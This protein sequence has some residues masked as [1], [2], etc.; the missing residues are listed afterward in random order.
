MDEEKQVKRQL[1]KNMLWN[2]IAF[3][4]I[5]YLFG[6]FVYS[7]FYGSL[8]L[9]ADS[10]LQTVI[11]QFSTDKKDRADIPKK[12]EREKVELPVNM[13]NPK[14]TDNDDIKEKHEMQNPRLI[15]I[16]R[17]ESGNIIEDS[18]ENSRVND[19]IKN[20]EFNKDNTY[21]IYEVLI[22]NTYSYRCVNVKNDEGNY[23]QVLIN[24]DAE[25]DIAA[26]FRKNLI[27]AII[28]CVILILIASYIL[29]RRTLR[30]I[31]D[32]WKKQTEFVQN[33]S[34]E[35]RT[36]LAVIKAKQENLLER[37][38]TKIID[39]AEDISI[40]L[41]ETQRLTKLIKELMDLAR[42]DS[43]KVMLNKELFKLDDEI[44][45]IVDIYLDVAKSES[46]ELKLNLSYD[47]KVYADI[48]K[49]KE[50]LI[51]LLDNSLKYTEK[52]DNIEVKTYKKDG[53]C[54][55]EVI[56]TG[57]GINKEDQEHI[58]ERFYRSEKSRNRESGG[59]GL[60]LSLAYNIVKIH[61]G[62]IKVESNGNK[63][64]KMI[65]KI[66]KS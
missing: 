1:I 29:S 19:Q 66:P 40:T 57:I 7:K 50:L 8:Y 45:S 55:I 60:G 42:N 53:K 24:I 37:P 39:N 15:F 47:D 4:I 35:L 20:V 62:T 36:P 43:N 49:L 65:V 2:L 23:V 54:C 3:S 11:R 26:K 32:S 48:N 41:K 25:K 17:D 13:D 58:F 44:K 30:P 22:N 27:V 6:T 51:I 31:I 21:E 56:D 38:N 46:K 12:Q 52:G 18:A 16:Y 10:E 9:S 5:F 63:G 33:A 34:H 61:K 28:V 64:T 59:M 14:D